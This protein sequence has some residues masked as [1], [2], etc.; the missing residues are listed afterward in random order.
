MKRLRAPLFLASILILSILGFMTAAP[1]V[2]AAGIA[3]KAKASNPNGFSPMTVGPLTIALGDALVVNVM[4]FGT[5]P[6]GTVTDSQGN[7]F[8]LAVQSISAQSSGA[9]TGIFGAI[10]S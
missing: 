1:P 9:S 4:W 8:T 7:R 3:F 6:A 5:G 10:A 2:H